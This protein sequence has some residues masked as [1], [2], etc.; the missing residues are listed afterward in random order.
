MCDKAT[1]YLGVIREYTR[2]I[3]MFGGFGLFIFVY[4]DFKGYISEQTEAQKETVKALTE[5]SVRIQEVETKLNI[6]HE[7][8]YN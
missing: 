2:E 1:G 4:A 5:L 6:K 8:H 7:Q 3:V